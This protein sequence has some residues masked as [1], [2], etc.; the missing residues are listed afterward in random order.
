MFCLNQPT[1][2]SR[3]FPLHHRCCDKAAVRMREA[4]AC[5]PRC[6]KFHSAWKIRHWSSWCR[7]KALT[8]QVAKDGRGE[9]EE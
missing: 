6:D 7:F 9:R 4:T 1:V 8:T 2:S 5:R 3:L